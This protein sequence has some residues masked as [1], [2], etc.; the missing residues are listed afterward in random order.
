MVLGTLKILLC[1]SVFS[2][3]LLMFD[4]P[5]SENSIERKFNT[6][7][8]TGRRSMDLTP[9]CRCQ[10][11]SLK[12]RF[13]WVIGKVFWWTPQERGHHKERGESKTWMRR[14]WFPSTPNLSRGGPFL[15]H[16]YPVTHPFPRVLKSRTYWESSLSE[17]IF[18]AIFLLPELAEAYFLVL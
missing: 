3:C 8:D 7:I 12:S 15:L 10:E 1:H 11:C 18:P 14:C 13:W 9:L 2:T 17:N 6:Y 4:I 16:S 5:S